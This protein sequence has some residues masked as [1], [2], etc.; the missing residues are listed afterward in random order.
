MTDLVSS[1]SEVDKQNFA[2]AA[3]RALEYCRNTS[4]FVDA[5]KKYPSP[6]DVIEHTEQEGIGYAQVAY[7]CEHRPETP[8]CRDAFRLGV[9]PYNDNPRTVHIEIPSG[10][11]E[12]PTSCVN[13]IR[14]IGSVD[15]ISSIHAEQGSLVHCNTAENWL[16]ALKN[17]PQ[18]L[19]YKSK[20]EIDYIALQ[21]SCSHPYRGDTP[22]CKDA[23]AKY[24]IFNDGTGK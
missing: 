3:I 6:F 14:G 9:Y 13:S 16:S 19:G 18:V 8:V 21:T 2:K 12:L 15:A 5:L 20:D 11:K 23:V 24:D 22:V 17:N 10:N 4:Y 7:F 1:E